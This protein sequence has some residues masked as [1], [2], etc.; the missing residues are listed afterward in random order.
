[1]AFTGSGLDAGSLRIDLTLVS[2]GSPA[3]PVP[4]AEGTFDPAML[5]VHEYDDTAFKWNPVTT[6]AVY[7]DTP[8]HI[9]LTWAAG[10]LAVDGR[11][12]VTLNSPHAAPVVDRKMRPLSPASFAT[13]FRLVDDGSGNLIPA[14]SL[15]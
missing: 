3:A 1:V 2:E 13:Q 10:T 6:T 4:L 8:P 7:N 5:A 15:F 11:Y 12:R 9:L 14:N